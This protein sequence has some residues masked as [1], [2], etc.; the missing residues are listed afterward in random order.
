MSLA[1]AI[2]ERANSSPASGRWFGPSRRRL[3]AGATAAL[4]APWVAKARSGGQADT[5]GLDFTASGLHSPLYVGLQRG[6]F[7]KAGIDSY[8]EDGNGSS[9]T[10][11]LIGAGLL[12]VGL[13]L[14]GPLAIA[15][16]KG[17]AVT[18]VAGRARANSA[19]CP[20]R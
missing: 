7:E 2:D 15:R 8:M 20:R 12:D 5:P 11:Q 4:I 6:W 1:A 19:S 14:L 13:N 18:S 17:L 16:A 3:L 9:T 10:V